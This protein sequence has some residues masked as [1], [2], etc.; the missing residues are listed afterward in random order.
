MSDSPASSQ[1]LHSLFPS[2][3][4]CTPTNSSPSPPLNWSTSPLLYLKDQ[5]FSPQS[6]HQ[7]NE[8]LLANPNFNSTHVFRADILSDTAAKLKSPQEKAA[9]CYADLNLDGD[10]HVASLPPPPP[11]IDPLPPWHFVGFNLSRTVV[12]RRN[13]LVVLRPHISLP[14][15]MPWYHPKVQA[16]AF[17][18]EY[19]PTLKGTHKGTLSVHFLPFQSSQSSLSPPPPPPIDISSRLERTLLSLLKTQARLCRKP[20]REEGLRTNEAE[21]R[22]PKDNILPQHIVQNRYALLKE[23]YA[24]W[25]M[26]NWVE[27]TE[28]SKHVFE[29]LGIA[30]FLC[31]LWEKYYITHTS[32]STV[33]AGTT[34]TTTNKKEK[35]VFP[36][37][38][39][40]ACGNGVLVYILHQEGYQGW[41]FDARRRKTWSILPQSTRE[42]LKQMIYIPKPF[43][44]ALDSAPTSP[45][46]DCGNVFDGIFNNET[47]IISNHAD[48]LTLWTPL[49]GALSNPTSPMPFFAIPCCSHA[50]SGKRY[51]Y[52]PPKQKHQQHKTPDKTCQTNLTGE[53]IET[54]NHHHHP[55]PVSGDLR[56]LAAQRRQERAD[57]GVGYSAYASLTAKLVEVAVEVGYAD[58]EKTLLRIPSTRNIGVIGGLKGGIT[59]GGGGEGRG[60]GGVDEDTVINAVSRIVTSE[61][62]TDG[63]ISNAAAAW[64]KRAEGLQKPEIT[65]RGDLSHS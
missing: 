20:L 24:P 64:V 18:Y 30:A 48:E 17:L 13:H 36:G 52:P 63:G 37:F 39:D 21:T 19:H 55:Q 65:P 38:V 31:E 51:R 16:V 22:T 7:V 58:V 2:P 62:K 11:L 41:G 10:H 40:I 43:L 23:K 4:A 3:V 53:P 27:R 42:K 1:F 33:A 57:P 50:L 44:Q 35:K 8:L 61:C 59:V 60:E 32:H 26:H 49:T 12:R 34:T 56:A 54:H 15:H 29:D 6:F 14:D 9:R 28:P 47:F 45:L 25:L 46:N 5:L